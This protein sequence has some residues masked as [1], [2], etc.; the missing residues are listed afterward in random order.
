MAGQIT[1]EWVGTTLIVTSDSGTSG[2]DLKGDRGDIG[3]R[4][5]QGPKGEK[6][7]VFFTVSEDGSQL[8]LDNY[9]DINV[10]GTKILETIEEHNNNNENPHNVTAEQVGAEPIGSVAT[11]RSSV[12]AHIEASNNPHNVT[13]EQVNLGNVD[14]TSDMD[15]PVSTA[16]AAAIN[17]VKDMALNNTESI[18]AINNPTTGIL[19]QAK[20]YA[21]SVGGG[22][23]GAVNSVNGMIGDVVLTKLNIEGLENVDNTADADKPV[24]TAQAAAMANLMPKSGGTFTGLVTLAYGSLVADCSAFEISLIRNSSLGTVAAAPSRNGEINWRYG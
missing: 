10:N 22:G 17:E 20:E 8:D 3:I 11:L 21:N 16:Q 5:P 14:N 6:P 2:C 18:N 24:S 15:K 12:I 7:E 23:G 19:A 13:A 9:S 4:G 1:H